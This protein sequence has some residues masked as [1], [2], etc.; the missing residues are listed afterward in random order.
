MEGTEGEQLA[1]VFEPFVQA[2][3]TTT[4]SFGGTGLGLAITHRFCEL[5]NATIDV[6]ST[7]GEGTTFEIVLQR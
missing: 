5:L 7:P 6:G 2:E 4:R 1:M 3:A